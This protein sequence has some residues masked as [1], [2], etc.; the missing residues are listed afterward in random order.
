MELPKAS[1]CTATLPFLTHPGYAT[2]VEIRAKQ[3]V[4]SIARYQSG[5]LHLLFGACCKRQLA[6]Q[7]LKFALLP[8]IRAG[9]S[10]PIAVRP[11]ENP[12]RG[13]L[14]LQDGLA[15]AWLSTAFQPIRSERAR[16]L[17]R[18]RASQMDIVAP[19]LSSRCM[20]LSKRTARQS[21]SSRHARADR[22]S[23]K[24]LVTSIC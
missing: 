20:R 12:F 11:G 17:W 16:Q 8:D 4:S 7:K 10:F 1:L 15:A 2:R 19:A 3:I 18:R 9:R 13:S 6:C 22:P 14:R 21:T 23:S 24:F 5:R